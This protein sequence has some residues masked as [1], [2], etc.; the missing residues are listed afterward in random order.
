MSEQES[1]KNSSP[2]NGS[3]VASSDKASSDK[4][5][6]TYRATQ[7]TLI[8]AERPSLLAPPTEKNRA[9]LTVLTGPAKGTLIRVDQPAI[10]LGRSELA[11]VGI[12]DPSLS[13]I[14][15]R[16]FSDADGN[17][18][19]DD[20]SST[21]GTYVGGQRIHRPTLLTDG[22]RVGLGKRTLARF[23]IQD[24]LEEHALL[25][26][27]ESALRDALTKAYNRSVFEDRLEGEMAFS[28]RHSRPLALLLL[29][30]DHFKSVND[31]H[32][33]PAGDWVLKK[34][35][36]QIHTTLRVEDIFARYGGEEFAILLRDCYPTEAAI[37]AER[38]RALIEATEIAFQG[39]CLQVTVSVGIASTLA[40]ISDTH[41]M[42]Q[43][44]DEAL[45]QAKAEGRNR[46]QMFGLPRRQLQPA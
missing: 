17:F 29:D 27:H 35:A 38:L 1:N 23:S 4:G 36:E 44:A 31:T 5:S 33:H 6:G 10:S 11:D 32:G 40:G 20:N 43:H 18:Y 39:Q 26:L 37:T 15:A 7:P 22:V 14:H 8:D 46:I 9:L 21:N 3:N 42:V 19:L 30:I 28:L 24:A 12:P 13:R 2:L 25:S 45:Y 41:E 16:V 34:V